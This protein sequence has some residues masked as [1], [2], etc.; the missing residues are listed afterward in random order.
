MADPI[1]ASPPPRRRLL[2][3]RFLLSVL[4]LSVL[5]TL[6]LIQ[7]A[8]IQR[9]GAG[10]AELA[11]SELLERAR[12]VASAHDQWLAE[13]R[14]LLTAM[15]SALN[16]LPAAEKS[17]T[18]L[19]KEFIDR[20]QG[21][22]TVL[23]ANSNGDLV[24]APTAVTRQVNFADRSYFRRVME[25]KA[26]SAGEYIVGR[27]S[28]KR[29]LPVALPMLDDAGEIEKVIIAGR[30]LDW[31]GSILERQGFLSNARVTVLDENGI[32]LG[33][34]P[35]GGESA[36]E[37]PFSNPEVLKAIRDNRSGVTET[38]IGE[39]DHRIIGFTRLN[40]VSG[41]VHV[42]VST[43]RDAAMS[44][45]DEYVSRGNLFLVLTMSVVL[46]TLW[47][48]LGILVLYPMERVREAMQRASEG[49]LSVRLGQTGLSAEVRT[50]AN[51]FDTM[52]S[53]L[54]EARTH[55]EQLATIDPLLDIA[56]RRKFDETLKKEWLRARRE[57]EPL[58][59]LMIDLDRFKSYNDRYGHPS[60]DACLQRV[61]EAVDRALRRPGD[62][63][64]RYGGE[65]LVCIL[66]NTDLEG[67]LVVSESIRA[68]VY[69]VGITHEDGIDNRI[70]VS[71]G[72]AAMVP[73][74]AQTAE[75]L[76]DAADRA[77]YAAK[78]AGR[79][80]VEA[81]PMQE[82]LKRAGGSG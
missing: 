20:A 9:S 64:A 54:G 8:A 12:L 17:C 6:A 75:E 26:F 13:S 58:A 81:S 11:Q 4:V 32:V 43:S 74:A 56:N 71:V 27:I 82:D 24:C 35:D 60:G 31:L 51:A 70:T 48:G 5:G 46:I 42:L 36:R 45:V 61:V 33:Q 52:A 73:D 68:N 21:F 10:Q 50:I 72:V 18:R 19:F 79:N 62:L 3:Q 76:L 23:L 38:A 69:D 49:D 41:D 40:R 15:A 63:L 7:A 80:R 47:A 2:S 67:A 57:R 25:T 39:S 78:T 29:V 65:E 77:L 30:E 55:L 59:L 22:D 44:L 1:P 28:G 16:A 66:P 53:A 34:Y 37:K 14:N